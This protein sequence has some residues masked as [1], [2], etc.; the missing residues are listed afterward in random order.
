VL[1]IAN[2]NEDILFLE[3]EKVKVMCFSKSVL[4]W[5]RFEQFTA[6]QMNIMIYYAL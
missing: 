3:V 6:V 5:Q 4:I 2:M 1:P